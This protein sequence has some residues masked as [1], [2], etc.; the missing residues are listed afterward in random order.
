LLGESVVR[1]GELSSVLYALCESPIDVDVLANELEAQ[2]GAPAD[3]TT[4]RATTDAVLEMVR[5]GV[6]FDG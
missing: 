6:L 2:F 5:A 4:L 1:L 3:R